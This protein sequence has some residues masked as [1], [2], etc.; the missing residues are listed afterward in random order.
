MINFKSIITSYIYHFTKAY[1]RRNVKGWKINE[2][3][4]KLYILGF[5]QATIIF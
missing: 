3:S 5:R 2:F 4:N 1:V